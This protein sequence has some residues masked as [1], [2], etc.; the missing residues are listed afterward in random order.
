MLHSFK[1]NS[2]L[3]IKSDLI[4]IVASSL[5]LIHC[6]STPLIF[7]SQACTKTCCSSSTPAYWK[8]VD[9]LFLL[10]SLISV[11]KSTE[12]S[13][14][15]FLR[16]SLWFSW[17]ALCFTISNEQV[18][19]VRLPEYSIYLPGLA[20]IILHLINRKYCKCTKDECCLST[21]NVN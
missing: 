2:L 9:L 13:T 4:G 11:Y 20:L 7:I 10:I 14:S 8:W 5:C 19:F 16:L 3:S 21:G 18:G 17:L 1:V 15:Q 6:I 12:R